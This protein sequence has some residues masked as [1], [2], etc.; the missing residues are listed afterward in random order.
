MPWTRWPI[1]NEYRSI[2]GGSLSHNI[3]SVIFF[4][5]YKCKKTLQVLFLYIMASRLVCL[6]VFWV[7]NEWVSVYACFLCSFPSISFVPIWTYYLLFCL[8]LF[9]HYAWESCLLSKRDG[10]WVNSDGS[11]DGESLGEGEGW[12]A[13]ITY[14]NIFNIGYLQ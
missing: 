10:K 5:F 13:V 6:W 8:I 14:V 12:E 9:Y 2:I 11:G 3:M 4:L 7:L 1:E